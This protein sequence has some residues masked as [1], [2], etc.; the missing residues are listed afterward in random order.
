MKQSE[1]HK[2]GTEEKHK[3]IKVIITGKGQKLS[4][5]IESAKKILLCLPSAVRVLLDGEV[6]ALGG[7]D[8]V[9]MT[10][11]GHAVEIVGVINEIHFE[12]APSSVR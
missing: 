7:T 10:Y 2:D 8:L 5:W 11:V 3:N 6:L 9:C 12:H 4:V 1:K